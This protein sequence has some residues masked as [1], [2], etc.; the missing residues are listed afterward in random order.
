[1]TD[2]E[3]T[4]EVAPEILESAVAEALA[5][6]AP[7]PA[8]SVVDLAEALAAA[9]SKVER[10]PSRQLVTAAAIS[11]SLTLLAGS[12]AVIG[13][14]V[15]LRGMSFVTRT[16]L[17]ALLMFAPVCAL[18]L[19]LLFEVARLVLQHPLDIPEPRVVSLRWT[20]GDREG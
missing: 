6:P 14:Y 19:A 13:G 9:Q 15:P 3:P 10:R 5:E 11:F 20:P 18:V 17:G 7:E 8:A 2:T 16:D 1:M 12:V 4:A